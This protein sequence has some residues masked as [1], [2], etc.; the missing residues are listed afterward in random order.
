[1]SG[2]TFKLLLQSDVAGI[3][4]LV[5]LDYGN[6]GR[7]FSAHYGTLDGRGSPVSG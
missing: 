2:W 4:P 1:M 5:H 6:A 7:F 3:E